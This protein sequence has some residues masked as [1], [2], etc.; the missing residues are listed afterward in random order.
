MSSYSRFIQ[1]MTT[2]LSTDAIDF[3]SAMIEKISQLLDDKVD[4]NKKD[5]ISAVGSFYTELKGG[6]KKPS[7]RKKVAKVSNDGDDDADAEAEEEKPKRVRKPTKKIEGEKRP[8]N[9]YQMFVKEQMPI[10]TEREKN[11]EEDEEKLD[12][13]A[14]MKEIS[15]LWKEHKEEKAKED[16]KDVDDDVEVDEKPKRVKKSAKKEVVAP[17]ETKEK[18]DDEEEEEDKPEPEVQ[19]EKPKKGKKPAKKVVD[20]EKKPLNAYQQFVKENMPILTE[21]EKNKGEDEEKLDRKALM[22][23][24][25]AMWKDF[26][27][28][29]AKKGKKEVSKSDASDVDADAD[30]EED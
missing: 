30:A 21:R 15:V 1:K 7:P 29:K 11:K 23:E 10:L 6:R 20:G 16:K 8:L 22:S 13:K 12:R 9:A 3:K 18:T 24:I 25:S 27:E 26:K 5:F 28:K 19:E 4:I 17:K 14:L 2:E